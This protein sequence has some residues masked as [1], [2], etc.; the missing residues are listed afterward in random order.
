[1]WIWALLAKDC[2]SIIEVT[3]QG[4]TLV[5]QENNNKNIN[6]ISGNNSLMSRASRWTKDEPVYGGGPRV[7][8]DRIKWLWG[9]S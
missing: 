9:P 2:N 5:T 4:L 7:F 3:W 6:K 1:M 8:W